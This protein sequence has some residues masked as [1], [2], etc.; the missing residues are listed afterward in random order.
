MVSPSQAKPLPR[1]IPP[2]TRVRLVRAFGRSESARKEV[3]RRFRIGYY[4]SNDGLD[5]VWLVNELG[6]YEQTADREFLLRHFEIEW[7][8]DETDYYGKTKRQLGP[9]RKK[10]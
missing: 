4:N 2:R 9:L 3:G 5:C 1:L 6:V 8:S 10:T 7:I